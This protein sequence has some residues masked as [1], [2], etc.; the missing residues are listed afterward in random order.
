M[1]VTRGTVKLTH[2]EMD[3]FYFGSGKRTFVMLPGMGIKSIMI[4]AEGVASAYKM[5][6]EDF[7]V[8]VFDRTKFLSENYSITALT[9]DT[10]EAMRLLGL[11]NACVFGTSQGGMMALLLAIHHP[12]LVGRLLLAST[13]SRDNPLA[14]QVMEKWISFA[15]QR[16]IDGFTDC[17]I[18][19]LY[20]KTFADKFGHLLK[21]MYRDITDEEFDRFIILAKSCEGLDAYEQLDRIQ[22]PAL[23][24]GAENDRVLGAQGSVEIAEKLGCELYLYGPEYGHCV[25]DEAPDYKDRIMAFFNAG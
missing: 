8:Y 23:V 9:E 17:F 22:C 24:I 13:M 12:E 10:A 2:N 19:V 25:F 6:A 16:D 11:Q 3:Y 1:K 15:E 4:S 21:V 7:T 18:D 20:S 14:H 5:F